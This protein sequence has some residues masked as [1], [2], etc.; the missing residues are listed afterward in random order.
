MKKASLILCCFFISLNLHLG[1]C[2]EK[3]AKAEQITVEG[4]STLAHLDIEKARDRALEDALRKAVEHGVGI[5]ISSQSLTKNYQLIEDRIL[6]KSS[7]Y[8]QQYN[9]INEGRQDGFYVVTISALVKVDD[10]KNDLR[11]IKILIEQNL[12]RL[13]VLVDEDFTSQATAGKAKNNSSQHQSPVEASLASEFIKKG[14]Y[15][16][17]SKAIKG[18]GKKGKAIKALQEDTKIA[19]L[20]GTTMNTDVVIIGEAH[21]AKRG[22]IPESNFVSVTTEL[23]VKVFQADTGELLTTRTWNI[24]GAGL[25]YVAAANNAAKRVANIAGEHLISVVLD[26]LREGTYG[27]RNIW[28]IVYDITDFS[29]LDLLEKELKNQVPGIQKLY[30]RSLDR[31]IAIYDAEVKGKTANISAGIHKRV[32][33]KLK[34][35][36][37]GVSQNV[38]KLKIVQNEQK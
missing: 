36:V 13:L 28:I 19:K 30:R 23:T 16:L 15:V 38:I 3:P 6:A 33:G 32:F 11:P 18:T 26:T 10:I 27:K 5:H 12:P 9:I 17:N 24:A 25:N 21:S 31:G 4:R 2:V 22:P 37:I 34:T 8:V 20:W 35:L 29:N 14:F 1:L 7:G